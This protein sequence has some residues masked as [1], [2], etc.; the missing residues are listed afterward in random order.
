MSSVSGTICHLCLGPL[1]V[2]P[3]PS[4]ATGAKAR[5]SPGCE[6][7]RDQRTG[8]AGPRRLAL[9]EGKLIAVVW[10]RSDLCHRPWS[11]RYGG[12]CGNGGRP[13]KKS[14]PHCSR[15]RRSGGESGR[16]APNTPL[17]AAKRMTEATGFEGVKIGELGL[18]I[19]AVFLPCHAVDTRRRTRFTITARTAV[20]GQGLFFRLR[21]PTQ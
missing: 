14:A 1:T 17:R 7:G 9:A 4:T 12:L 6:P 11:F 18:E 5:L 16:L 8:R 15:G 13:K 3:V 2:S 20:T 19:L 10:L 21:F